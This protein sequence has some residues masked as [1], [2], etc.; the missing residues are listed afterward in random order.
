MINDFQK[1]RLC[2]RNFREEDIIREARKNEK[3]VCNR[4][5]DVLS[6]VYKEDDNYDPQKY[7]FVLNKDG[8]VVRASSLYND[9]VEEL[10]YDDNNELIYSVLTSG[11]MGVIERRFFYPDK[12]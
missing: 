1:T 7:S 5:N 9:C 12:K 6:V 3:C 8:Y 2:R 11:Q 4:I 10:E